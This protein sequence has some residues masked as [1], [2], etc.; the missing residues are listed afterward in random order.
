MP[1]VPD[2]MLNC[3]VYMYPTMDDAT[4][5]TEFGATGFFI[6]VKP[7]RAKDNIYLSNFFHWY[8]VTN[9]HVIEDGDGNVIRWNNTE[10]P[11]GLIEVTKSD[12]F[13]DPD[14]DLAA[15]PFQPLAHGR[16]SVLTSLDAG[17]LITPEY[18]SNL[19]LGIGHEVMYIGRYVGHGGK[20]IN[21]PSLRF[22][23][24]SM[25]PNDREPIEIEPGGRTQVSFLVES[26]S[27]AGY[28]GSPVFF[29]RQSYDRK[30]IDP[31]RDTLI[32][33]VDW[34]HIPER[35]Q[36]C[37][38]RGYLHASKWYVEIHS[39]MMCVVPSWKLKEFLMSPP[40]ENGRVAMEDAFLS[41]ISKHT[42]GKPDAKIK[43]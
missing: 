24:I 28:S 2:W 30:E 19:D 3:V 4:E 43:E 9:K 34:G 37:D 26:R 8:V 15:L 25:M 42:T 7:A 10:G 35:V 39:G 18:A 5:G 29:Y 12:W 27:R 21:T 41:E 13:L 20:T 40:L 1:R 11:P 6:R 38:P 14:N 16:H 32:L 23:N 17:S 36:L 22:G 31:E 33:G